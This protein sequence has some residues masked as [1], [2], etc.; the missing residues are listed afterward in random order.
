M[1]YAG[2]FHISEI[3]DEPVNAADPEQPK[4]EADFGRE[5]ALDYLEHA[6]EWAVIQKNLG[7]DIPDGDYVEM[8]RA[9]IAN[10][11]SRKYWEGFNSAL[12]DPEAE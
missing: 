1:K 8:R 4:T 11:D 12:T 9:G 10:P 7:D 3:A 5:T 2:Y 6:Q